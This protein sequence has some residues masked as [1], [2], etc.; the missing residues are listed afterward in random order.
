MTGQTFGQFVLWLLVAAIF[1]G[2]VVWLLRLLYHRSTKGISFVRTG[3]GGEKVVVGGGALVW[4]IVHEVTPVSMNVARMVVECSEGNSMITHDRLRVD[5]QA[6]F[7]VRVASSPQAVATAA[8]ALGNKTFDSQHLAE[9]F[10]GEFEGALRSVAAEMSLDRI[11]EQRAEFVASII[12]RASPVLAHN[13]LELENV[14][15]RNLDQSQLE[16]FNSSNRFDSEGLTKLIGTIEERRQLRNDIEK[17]AMV[18]IRK[19]DLDAERQILVLEQE[20]EASRA[21]QKA[22]IAKEQAAGDAAADIARIEATQETDARKIQQRK[23]TEEAEI[24][25]EEKLQLSRVETERKLDVVRVERERELRKLEIERGKAVEIA[26]IEKEVHM[27]QQRAAEARVRTETEREVAQVAIAEEQVKSARQVEIT[28]RSAEMARM[29]AERDAQVTRIAAEAEQVRAQVAAEA[30]RLR[31]EADNVLT[32]DARLGRLRAMV[33][34]RIEGIISESVKPIE[35]ID[36]I[37]VVSVSGMG[38]AGGNRNPTDEV[39]DSAMRYRMQAPLVDEL[40]KDIGVDGAK[41]SGMGDIFRSAKDANALAKE[42]AKNE[43][44]GA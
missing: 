22:Q 35:K 10:K 43:K 3:M 38:G 1:V 37:K 6:D 8:A 9:F 28:R 32:E 24:A 40:L 26:E 25:A 36:S 44:E 12:E 39:V 11:H 13:G 17:N 29:D 33:I 34:E 21:A 16:Y 41:V 2:I 19:R 42:V 27:L 23:M 15:I 5:V 20:I 30:D 18:A 7:F 4:P 14:A 31:N